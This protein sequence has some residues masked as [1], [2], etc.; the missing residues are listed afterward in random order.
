MLFSGKRPIDLQAEFQTIV[1]GRVNSE[2][3]GGV[4]GFPRSPAAISVLLGMKTRAL[5]TTYCLHPR[6]PCGAY[7]F[8][9]HHV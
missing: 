3:N 1:V 6:M 4:V 8:C 2:V 5:K 7:S 9:S